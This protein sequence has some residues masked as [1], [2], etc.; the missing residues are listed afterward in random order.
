M[1]ERKLALRS[2]KGEAVAHYKLTM[3]AAHTVIAPEIPR[4]CHHLVLVDRS[5]SMAHTLGDLK[6]LL[7][8]LFTLEEYRDQESLL[9]F[10]SYAGKG[11]A[12]VHFNRVSLSDIMREGSEE[13]SEVLEL[14][15]T[16]GSD[17]RGALELAF[18]CI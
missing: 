8:K 13:L 5:S 14:N 17:L 4:S 16:Q 18:T 9:T 15:A 12:H 2:L 7:V 11:D 3:L 1:T 6:H 10:I